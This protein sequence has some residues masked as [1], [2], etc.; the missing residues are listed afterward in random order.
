MNTDP[1]HQM[2]RDADL[3]KWDY[4]KLCYTVSAD[5]DD[6]HSLVRA[7]ARTC[8][9]IVTDTDQFLFPQ[10]PPDVAQR[11]AVAHIQRHFD[12]DNQSI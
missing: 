6:L 9:N 8:C 4:D 3:I 12:L 11:I 10:T 5:V 2:L 1:I 7:V